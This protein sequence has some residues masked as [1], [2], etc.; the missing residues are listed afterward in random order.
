MPAPLLVALPTATA[1]P[2]LVEV[3]DDGLEADSAVSYDE[4]GG[5]WISYVGRDLG[6]GDRLLLRGYFP[7]GDRRG[8]PSRLDSGA[9]TRV[10]TPA[11]ERDANGDQV[12][13]WVGDD[14]APQGRDVYMVR[15]GPDGTPLGPEE[16][17]NVTTGGDQQHPRMALGPATE[18]FVFESPDSDGTGI[19][20]RLSTP[21]GFTSG[22]LVLN[23]W[24]PGDQRSPDVAVG[25]TGDFLLVWQGAGDGLAD[26]IWARTIR[27]DGVPVGASVLV[28]DA[29]AGESSRPA[30]AASPE[31]YLVV[32]NHAP[33]MGAPETV[34]A[35]GLDIK[36]LPSGAEVLLAG[37]G[38]T[39]SLDPDVAD[40]AG[41]W[42][43]VWNDFLEDEEDLETSIRGRRLVSTT[44]LGPPFGIREQQP[45]CP[46][47]GPATPRIAASPVADDFLVVWDELGRGS[48]GWRFDGPPASEMV[49]DLA[50]D[51]LDRD[52]TTA[53]LGLA[54]E[55]R[56]DHRGVCP[57]GSTRIVQNLP[58]AALGSEVTVSEAYGAIDCALAGTVLTCDSS[59]VP[60]GDNRQYNVSFGSSPPLPDENATFFTDVEVT[61][62]GIDPDSSND[63]A[64]EETTLVTCFEIETSRDGKGLPIVRTPSSGFPCEGGHQYEGREFE[65]TAEGQLGW[66]V[67][68]WTGTLD[69]AST[70][71]INQV[72]MPGEAHQVG[73]DYGLDGVVS[74]W[75]G[76]SDRELEDLGGDNDLTAQGTPFTGSGFS[77]RGFEFTG[78]ET[79]TAA[80]DAGLV[81]DDRDTSIG[82]WIRATDAGT[83]YAL[84]DKRTAGASAPLGVLVFLDA[85][86]PGF[87][88]GDGDTAVE[89]TSP[90]EITDDEWHQVVLSHRFGRENGLRLHVDGL[91]VA[92]DDLQALGT[93]SNPAD[94][95]F[96]APSPGFSGAPEDYDEKLD[97]VFVLERALEPSEILELSSPRHFWSGDGD[98]SDRG[99]WQVDGLLENG[100]GF[101]P[102]VC[103]LGFD[104]SS[105]GARVR[106]P[107]VEDS[108]FIPARSFGMAARFRAGPSAGDQNLID[109][110]HPDPLEGGVRLYLDEG[111]L[112]AEMGRLL[113][114]Y[115]TVIADQLPDPRDGRPHF[116]AISV[117]PLPG[118]QQQVTLV[119]DGDSQTVTVPETAG[120]VAAGDTILGGPGVDAIDEVLFFDRPLLAKE[121]VAI[122]NACVEALFFDGF[123][124]GHTGA[125]SSVDSR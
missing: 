79:L 62:P 72:L 101:G 76:D 59:F 54:Y 11:I 93:T 105:P 19:V 74:W 52:P 88:F 30:V 51:I 115:R 75:S 113:T 57:V 13:A 15:S 42:V 68:R 125:W 111:R 33:T 44:E 107:G 37:D 63:F 81:L 29:G 58:E 48:E 86:R 99:A 27:A 21:D 1:C 114:G 4:D 64:S 119:L 60:I 50:V 7:N 116:A 124:R 6:L 45:F 103:G 112:A 9:H 98:T 102:G 31:G 26:G 10:S 24:S 22:E 70:E 123:E 46:S 53:A 18:L 23:D 122:R 28:H 120:N 94:L 49:S 66:T 38:T 87:Q 106:F 56:I 40:T 121:I 65:T 16:L 77:D 83:R 14:E 2:F 39:P 71:R 17:V 108:S 3:P 95:R 61:R 85:G 117:K 5:Y 90:F 55:V 12:V 118:F 20:G 91:L 25:A 89:V 34:M 32:W 35:R 78:S 69:D 80:D 100:A 110:R 41:G 36:G 84:L 104:L 43:V 109:K 82:F 67:T 47:C 8:P 73:V 96:G 97:E 92:M